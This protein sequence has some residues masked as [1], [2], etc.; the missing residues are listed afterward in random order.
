MIS[1][2]DK[3]KTFEKELDA[4]IERLESLAY[5]GDESLRLALNFIDYLRADKQ[6]GPASRLKDGFNILARYFMRARGGNEPQTE[7]LVDDLLFGGHYFMLREYL[8][9]TFNAK[10][11]FMWQFGP[12][13]VA[14]RFK[15]SS[16]PRQF[17][18]QANNNLMTSFDTF[19]GYDGPTR[20]MSLLKGK[21]EFLYSND[22]AEA[23]KII[24]EMVELK[25][26]LYY[27]FLEPDDDVDLGGYRYRDSYL[28][29]KALVM[30]ALYHRYHH[31]ANES[32][33][34][35]LVTVPNLIN[36]LN[37][38]T[39]LPAS[40]CSR[41]L[42]DMIYTRRA[43][44]EKIEPVYFSMYQLRT[45]EQIAFSPY[46]LSV[47]EGFINLFR[48]IALRRPELFLTNLSM[49]L[50]ANLVDNVANMFGQQGFK[51]VKNVRLNH[52]DNRLPD[53]DVLV[54][55]EE[56]TF[57]YVL[58]C[59]EVKNPIPPQWA[60]DHLRVLNEGSVAKAFGQ[61]DSIREFFASETGIAFL[62]SLF[63]AGGLPHFGQEF[64]IGVSQ[65]VV[66]SRNAGMFFSDKEHIVIDYI[67]LGRILEKCDGDVVYVMHALRELGNWADTCLEITP[68]N[69]QVGRTAVTYEAVTVKRLLA[70]N[71]AAFKSAGVDRQIAK[72]FVNEGGHPFDVLEHLAKKTRH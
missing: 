54:I 2:I 25:F 52:F 26:G 65:V 47:T 60:K 46:E 15:D 10:D 23:G 8:Y 40:V 17:F 18:I 53:I 68:V 48:V 28:V 57:G 12:E 61:L 29:F 33:G 55:S 9:Y 27:T 59:C 37:E 56:P 3:I 43:N 45:D 4:A 67:T 20:I 32:P 5:D 1:E 70:F 14:V 49:R 51:C 62:H 44:E 31:L 34:I 22:I 50:A 7:K 35:L 6:Q 13:E 36:D 21:N 58:F 69:C 19:E 42:E 66:T 41:V 63:P 72:D 16:I 11:S 38:A 30:K 39:D 64:L 71:Q 24:E